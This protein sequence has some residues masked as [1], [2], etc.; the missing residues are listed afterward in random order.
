M[1][2][3]KLAKGKQDKAV[4]P[5]GNPVSA[6]TKE[7]KPHSNRAEIA[8]NAKTNPTIPSRLASCVKET[9]QDATQQPDHKSGR[10]RPHSSLFRK[11]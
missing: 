6:A 8:K 3:K 4:E 5:T 11:H 9:K 2:G 1:T 10:T 7:A